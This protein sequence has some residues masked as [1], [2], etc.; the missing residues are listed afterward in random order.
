VIIGGGAIGCFAA[1]FLRQRR[2]S[3]LVIEKGAAC[4]AASGSNFG[5]L[6]LQGR[7]PRQFPLALRAQAI[8]EDLARLSGEDAGVSACGHVYLGLSASDQ[9]KLEQTANEAQAAGLDVELLTG[10]AARQHWPMLSARVTGAC[11]SRRDAIADPARAAPIIA[12]LA[13]R[14]GAQFIEHTRVSKIEPTAAGFRLT[15]DRDLSISCGQLINA[16]GAWG[17]EIAAALGEE[18]PLIAAGPPLFSV[19]PEHSWQGPSL[20]AI[21]GTVLLRPGLGGDAVAGAFPRVKADLVTGTAT[22]PSDCVGRGLALLAAVLPGLGCLQAGR[23]WSGVEGYLPDLLP[24]LD[25][26][27]TTPGLLHAFGGCGH[28]YQLAPGVGAVAAELIACSAT[29]TPIDAFSI[30][31]FAD[32]VTPDPKLWQE[33]ECDL[34]ARFRLPRNASAAAPRQSLDP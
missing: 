32:G 13:E 22:V 12:R 19:R 10:A 3:V 16:A 14:A 7:H 25:W 26:S 30:A 20:A 1:Y 29:D 33:F 5:N 2:Q 27:Q 28:G 4:R 34:V 24:V 21:D 23:V 11:W 18:V 15:G 31:R 6:R 8:W 9:P 17:A